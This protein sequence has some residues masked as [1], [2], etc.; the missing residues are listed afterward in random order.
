VNNI[1]NLLTQKII[2]D[3]NMAPSYNAIFIFL[4]A[5]TSCIVLAAIPGYFNSDE[6]Q[7]MDSLSRNGFSETIWSFDGMR[8]NAFFR[9]LGY[10][11]LEITL[12]YGKLPF[13]AHC[14]NVV[15]HE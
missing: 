14:L 8:N 6:L 15:I 3:F 4:F 2:P 12:F 7:I 1:K 9:P 11:L 13:I 10:Q 5:V